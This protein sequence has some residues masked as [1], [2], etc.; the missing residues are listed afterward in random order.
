MV[1]SNDERQPIGKGLGLAEQHYSLLKDMMVDV[2]KTCNVDP[3]EN[4]TSQNILPIIRREEGFVK[5]EG[6]NGNVSYV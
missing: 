4:S 1:S 3:R 2:V 6:G 5:Q